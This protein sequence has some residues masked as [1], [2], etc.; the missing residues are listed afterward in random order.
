VSARSRRHRPARRGALAPLLLSGAALLG[1]AGGYLWLLGGTA[2]PAA[3]IGGPFTLL[4]DTGQV[5]T[6]RSFRGRYL[7]IHFGYTGCAD[8]CPTTL[9]ALRVALDLLGGRGA[10]VQPLFITVD[11][12]RD[13]PAVL[14]GYTAAFTPRLLGLTGTEQQLAAVRRAYHVRAVVHPDGAGYA[15]DHTSVLLLVGP[16]GRFIAPIAADQSGAAMAAE[17]GRYLAGRS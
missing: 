16:D 14:R 7:L 10:G 6:D 9:A 11:P 5:V 15:I 1:L 13:T 8:V 4:A 12:R 17:L 2:P 3:E